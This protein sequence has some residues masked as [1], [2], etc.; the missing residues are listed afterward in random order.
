MVMENESTSIGEAD[1]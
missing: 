1:M